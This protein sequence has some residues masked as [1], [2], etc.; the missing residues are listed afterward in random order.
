MSG[1]RKVNI[2][3]DEQAIAS[4]TEALAREIADAKPKDL[5]Q[6]NVAVEMNIQ[7]AIGSVADGHGTGIL[8]GATKKKFAQEVSRSSAGGCSAV[9]KKGAGAVSEQTAELARDAAGNEGAAVH[10]R[11]NHRDHARLAGNDQRLRHG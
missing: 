8:A 4:R 1:D 2:L 10:V 5:L 7:A 3:Y 9:E 6:V 11:G